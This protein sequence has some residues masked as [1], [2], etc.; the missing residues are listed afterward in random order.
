MEVSIGL[1]NFLKGAAGWVFIAGWLAV[2]GGLL[3]YLMYNMYVKGKD[4]DRGTG[5]HTMSLSWL[6]MRLST[7]PDGTTVER[8]PE[9][10]GACADF[11]APEYGDPRGGLPSA[12]SRTIDALHAAVKAEKDEELPSEISPGTNTKNRALVDPAYTRRNMLLLQLHCNRDRLRGVP[13][14]TPALLRTQLAMLTR[15]NKLS[16][17][18]VQMSIELEQSSEHRAMQ[19][20]GG[21]IAARGIVRYWDYILAIIRFQQLVRRA[22]ASPPCRPR[23]PPFHR[24]LRFPA[25]STCR[26]R[27][28]CGRRTRTCGRSSRRRRLRR[29]SPRRRRAG[30]SRPR[31]RSTCRTSRRSGRCP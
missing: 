7:W 24:A 8:V 25:P 11:C 6:S 21:A 3:P 5:L 9:I 15:L 23:L 26:P 12:D 2:L 1:P 13:P 28:A 29:S 22:A 30:R 20:G 14:L 31:W 17:I 16:D 10:I 4:R 19:Q 27:K 18:M